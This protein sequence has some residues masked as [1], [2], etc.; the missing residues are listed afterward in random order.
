MI[1]MIDS[2]KFRE[3]RGGSDWLGTKKNFTLSLMFM[4]FFFMS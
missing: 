4:I 2:K 3:H 1:D